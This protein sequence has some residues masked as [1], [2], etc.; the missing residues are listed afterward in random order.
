[1]AKGARILALLALASVFS[2]HLGSQEHVSRSAWEDARLAV[3][4]HRGLAGGVPE[5]TLAAFT[6][7]ISLGVHLIEIDVRF[8]KDGHAV[9][10]HDRSVNRTTNGEGYVRNMT[11]SEISS[12]DAGSWV[13]RGFAG[14]R[15]PTLEEALALA[16]GSRTGLLLDIKEGG[17]AELRK[18][19]ALVERYAAVPS[20]LFGARSSRALE[21]LQRINPNLN[22]IGFIRDP[23]LIEAFAASGARIIRLWPEWIAGDPSLITR[24]HAL[25]CQVWVTAGDAGRGE[26]RTLTDLGVDGVLTDRPEIL[27]S[28]Q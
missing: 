18:I 9:I 23:E 24:V 22:F 3:V 26:V 7:A 13:S 16:A 25:G 2:D 10:M 15:V 4:A 27:L 6:K 21:N 11:L 28:A 8:T 14:Q 17:D 5:N 1:M 19:V 12:L 20:T